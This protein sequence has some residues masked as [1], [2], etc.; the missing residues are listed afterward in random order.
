MTRPLRGCETDYP[1][2]EPIIPD[3]D[4]LV[5]FVVEHRMKILIYVKENNDDNN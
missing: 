4:N 5:V 3:L 2:T 1:Q